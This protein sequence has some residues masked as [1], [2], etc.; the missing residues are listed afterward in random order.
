MDTP[1][2]IAFVQCDGWMEWTIATKAIATASSCGPRD[3]RESLRPRLS[4]GRQLVGALSVCGGDQV[5]TDCRKGAAA[6]RRSSPSGPAPR[7]RVPRQH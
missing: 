6:P 1:Q 3:P 5:G 2:P 7:S 4:R